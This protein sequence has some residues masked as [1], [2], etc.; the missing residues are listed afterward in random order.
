[1]VLYVRQNEETSHVK[2][3][4]FCGETIPSELE[5]NTKSVY[6]IPCGSTIHP[7]Y[8][9]VLDEAFPEITIDLVGSLSRTVRLPVR[10][11]DL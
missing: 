11:T 8:V 10:V 2:L 5:A 9:L 6:R 1:M 4:H 3:I 7:K